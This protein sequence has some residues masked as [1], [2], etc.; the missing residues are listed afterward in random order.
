MKEFSYMYET[1]IYVVEEHSLPE[2]RERPILIVCPRC[3]EGFFLESPYSRAAQF[4]EA[5]SKH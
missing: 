4:L 1:T 5:T 3:G 2:E